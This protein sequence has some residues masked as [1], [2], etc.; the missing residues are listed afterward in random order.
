M[1]ENEPIEQISERMVTWGRNSALYRLNQRDMSEHQLFTALKR[2]ASTK[3]PGITENC[4]DDLARRTID[5]CNELR[6]LNDDNFAEV[7]VRSGV[8]SGK[9]RRRI[10]M[11]LQ[12]KGIDAEKANTALEEVDDTKAIIIFCRKRAFG[13][14]RRG[15]GDEARNTKELSALV[16]QGFAFELSKKVL[17]L[18]FDEANDILD[19][20]TSLD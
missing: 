12:E 18:Q 15:E 8:S 6:L 7:K 5:Y 16:R 9:S 13:P 10:A 19:G 11:Q 2:K 14:F 20:H 17:K 3:F 1:N 4:A